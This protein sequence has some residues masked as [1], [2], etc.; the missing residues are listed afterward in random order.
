M[1]PF[2]PAPPPPFMPRLHP[3]PRPSYPPPPAYAQPFDHFDDMSLDAKHVD[4]DWKSPMSGHSNQPGKGLLHFEIQ[5]KQ[6]EK[7]KQQ[8][9]PD[10]QKPKAIVTGTA[11]TYTVSKKS[12]TTNGKTKTD[13]YGTVTNENFEDK[14]DLKADS[15]LGM[16]S[17]LWEDKQR[18]PVPM[19]FPGFGFFNHNPFGGGGGPGERLFGFP[20]IF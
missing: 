15:A 11:V 16:P 3:P 17:N 19:M 5:K 10:R 12:A 20:F 2:G 7:N 13:E 9:K 18:E 1:E 14:V 4:D 6:N 8:S